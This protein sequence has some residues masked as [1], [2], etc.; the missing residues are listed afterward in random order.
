MIGGKVMKKDILILWAIIGWLS[1]ASIMSAIAQNM[2][3][4]SKL[5]DQTSDPI[6]IEADKLDVLENE[7][8]A[9]FSGNVFVVQK[10]FKLWTDSVVVI[11]G[12]QGP[13]DLSS[14]EAHGSVKVAFNDQIVTGNRASYDAK[15]Q[16]FRVFDNVEFTQN[17]TIIHGSELIIDLNTGKVNFKS[18]D[19]SRVR[20]VFE[21]PNN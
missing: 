18:G 1:S 16:T 21:A 15:G 6:Q 12:S 7:N 3:G 17:T 13:S 20:G 14:A 11:Y 5:P 8:R 2:D 9:I 19:S 4:F 10:N